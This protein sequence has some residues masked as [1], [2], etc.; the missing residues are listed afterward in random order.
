M[1]AMA[2][3]NILYLSSEVSPFVKVGGLADV[4]STFPKVLKDQN[5]DIR[6]FLP[7]YKAI[8]DRKFNLREV[9]RLREIKVPFGKETHTV[10]VKSGFIPNSKVQAYFLEYKPFFERADI[11][12][13][14]NTGEGWNDNYLRFAFFSKAA[15]EM[16]KVLFWQPDIIHCN[17]WQS[18]LTPHYLKTVY[19]DD[20]F[21][22]DVRTVLTL[23][24]LAYQG[25]FDASVAKEI[26]EES[27]PFDE[28]HSGW[29]HGRFNFLKAGILTADIL[30][31][32]SPN[33]A[34]EITGS[35]EY[36]Y[37]LE[38]ALTSR[39]DHLFGIVNGINTE[40]WNPQTDN[41]L[42]ANYTAEDLSPKQKNRTTLIDMLKL[43]ASAKTMIIGI[44]SRLVIQKGMDL[45]LGAGNRLM[46]LPI[47]LIILGKG[48]PEIEKGLKK[49]ADRFPGRISFTSSFNNKLAHQIE[50]GAD[51]FLMPSIY[52]PCGLNQIYSQ[53]YGTVPIVRRTGGLLDTVIEFNS[54][55][56]EG[57]GFFFK[58]KTPEALLNAVQRAYKCFQKPELWKKIARNGMSQDFSWE[59]SVEQYLQVYNTVME[60]AVV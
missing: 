53:R 51:A 45:L 20:P 52:E 59:H 55:T 10:S 24:N 36:G 15:F 32:V 47:C 21:F 46:E 43:N 29:F 44:I 33:Y 28:Q 26:C 34:E 40:E 39:K 9:I 7:K 30:T 1:S 11:Y 49:L 13:D 4:A 56:G 3:F 14:P 2:R 42:T 22:K 23:H 27:I 12:V 41:Y 38:D 18:A 5:H 50:A 54:K 6:V 60:E 19:K 37:G 17:D 31:T 58:E 16:L 35:N 25:L 57:T 48:Q 8:R